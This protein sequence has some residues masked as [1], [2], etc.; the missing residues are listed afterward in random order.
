[1]MT[2]GYSG[3]MAIDL[4]GLSS[5]FPPSSAPNTDVGPIRQ[6]IIDRTKRVKKM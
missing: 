4:G 3:A 1:M 5:F 2:P 6:A